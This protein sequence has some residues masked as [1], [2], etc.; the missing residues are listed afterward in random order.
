MV[1]VGVTPVVYSG[2]AGPAP[3]WVLLGIGAVVLVGRW[4]LRTPSGLSL[5]GAPLLAPAAALGAAA[6]FSLAV[7]PSPGLSGRRLVEL[8]SLVIVSLAAADIARDERGRSRV[9]MTMGISAVGVGLIG[10]WQVLVPESFPFWGARGRFVGSVGNS[11]AAAG[12]LAAITLPLLG[13]WLVE[14]SAPGRLMAGGAATWLVICVGATNARAAWLALAAGLLVIAGAALRDAARGPLWRRTR[15]AWL[16]RLGV[17]TGLGAGL[18][19]GVL[20]GR[21]VD[22]LARAGAIFDRADLSTW[23]RLSAWADTLRMVRDHPLLGVG[24]GNFLPG[25][26]RYSR[27][28]DEDRLGMQLI[29]HPHNELLSLAGEMGAVGSLALIALGPVLVRAARRVFERPAP[30]ARR[31]ELA[32]Y[33]GGLVVIAVNALGSFPLH[34]ADSAL[35]AAVLLGFVAGLTAEASRVADDAPLRSGGRRI[36]GGL[37]AAGVMS[38]AVALFGVRPAAGGFLAGVG[39]S[40]V[41]QG[42]LAQAR[43]SL[44]RARRWFPGDP[45]GGLFLIEVLNRLR[46]FGEAADVGSALT[47]EQPWLLI[48]YALTSRAQ[49]EQG[50]L[51]EAEETLRRALAANPRF[52]N[53]LVNLAGLAIR[54]QEPAV[55]VALLER[56][57]AISPAS[58][59]VYLNLGTAYAAGGRWPE[60]LRSFERASALRPGSAEAWYGVA[61]ARSVAGERQASLQALAKAV[62]LDAGYRAAAREEAAF[63]GLRSDPRFAQVVGEQ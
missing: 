41:S 40:E 21:G 5:A 45:Y 60:A 4:A 46:R 6:L 32:G 26:G 1:L 10:L 7:A 30:F 55:A 63:A 24:V 54:R 2:Y 62:S 19:I 39:K 17:V 56:A 15:W 25:F 51:S 37:A 42:K 38:V 12:F 23:I 44:E 22:V 50:R 58:L 53:A 14:R 9:V 61:V 16:G 28:V 3:K 31:G 8:A 27:L 36:P 34:V 18:G 35:V 57:R 48:G 43:E 20:W 13:W 11:N 59:D 47:S 29:D 52:T 33:F 49:M